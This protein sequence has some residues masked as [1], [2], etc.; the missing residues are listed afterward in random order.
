MQFPIIMTGGKGSM[1]KGVPS[2]KHKQAP[3]FLEQF[4]ALRAKLDDYFEKEGDGT[5]AVTS[6]IAEEGKSVTSL[7]LAM[8][9]AS[10]RRRKVLLLDTDMRKSSL[11]RRMNLEPAPG[12]SEF[13]T[14]KAKVKEILRNSQV[15]G[16]H[17]I[18]AGSESHTAADMLAGEQF[19][20]FLKSVREN[21]DVVI[22][23]TP[24]VLPVADALSLRDQVARFLLVFRAGFTPY[25][26]L[27]QAI[28]EIGERKV[29]GVVI[30]RVKPMADKYYK[31]YYG[32]YYRK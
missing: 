18:P 5:L 17:A 22:L 23:D 26:M 10:T 7:N 12:L 27:R 2:L 16:L 19:R 29:L 20:S 24:P 28:E 32:N 6:A 9:I 1:E 8:N 15:P 30:N 4:R 13:L 21:F 14:G 11:A 3:I 25:P 31:Q